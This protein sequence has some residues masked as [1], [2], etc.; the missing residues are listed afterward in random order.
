V[1]TPI[2][3]QRLEDAVERLDAPDADPR[4]VEASL[5]DLARINRLLGGTRL[6][7]RALDRLLG[8]RERGPLTLLD[9]GSGGGD[10]ATA[11]AAW[12]RRQG[13][14]PRVIAVDASEAITALAA[15]RVGGDVEPRIGDMRAL[16][17]GD[18]SVDV[19][20]CSLVIHHLEP[21]EA[22][23][24]L[25]ELRR[26][27]RIGVVV[28]DLVR[29]RLGLVGAHTVIRVLTRNAI[30]RHDAVLSVRRAYTRREL[31]ALVHE[32]GL[33]PVHVRGWLGYR[34]AIAAEPA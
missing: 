33:R 22:V 16:D 29:T 20:T 18:D 17:L 34:V 3:L 1:S 6:T 8:G 30:T 10:M 21:P 23:R 24:A 28:N 14:E 19:A 11:L 31:L 12:A 2:G 4:E 27:A 7:E 15:E 5:D 25:R 32:A 26:V 9:A 13:F